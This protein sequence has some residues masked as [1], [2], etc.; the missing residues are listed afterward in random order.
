MS[1]HDS[2]HVRACMSGHACQGM[3]VRASCQGMIVV[4]SG[5]ACQGM[6]VVMSGHA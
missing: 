1:G 2:S 4:M 6:I 3:H 5:H